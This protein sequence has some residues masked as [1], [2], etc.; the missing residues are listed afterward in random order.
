MGPGDLNFGPHV[1]MQ[2]PYLLS[3]FSSPMLGAKLETPKKAINRAIIKYYLLYA[4]SHIIEE[5]RAT[6]KYQVQRH[7]K[8]VYKMINLLFNVH[9]SLYM[10][11]RHVSLYKPQESSEFSSCI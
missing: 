3:H 5:N 8:T 10:V 9:F 2:A 4:T 6:K 7:S 11:L 1:C